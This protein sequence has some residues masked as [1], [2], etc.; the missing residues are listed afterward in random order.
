MSLFEELLSSKTRWTPTIAHQPRLGNDDWTI[1]D[2]YGTFDTIGGSFA[3][4]KAAM[5]ALSITRTSFRRSNVL[6]G[7]FQT[8]SA[9]SSR[10]T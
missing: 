8:S 2:D 3:V 4:N 10:T 6:A 5:I 7:T 9:R 1:T